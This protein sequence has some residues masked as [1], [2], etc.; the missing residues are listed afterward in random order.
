MALV[1]DFTHVPGE[2]QS[3]HKPVACGWKIFDERGQRILQL[4]TYGYSDRVN[5]GKLSQS[6]QFDRAAAE[7]LQRLLQQ[8]FPGLNTSS[9]A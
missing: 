5:P 1:S 2:R 4:D 6:L 7:E 8:A 3:I 9:N